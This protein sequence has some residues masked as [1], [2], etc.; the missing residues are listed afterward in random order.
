MKKLITFIGALLVLSLASSFADVGDMKQISKNIKDLDKSLL[1]TVETSS[2][3]NYAVDSKSYTMLPYNI[4]LSRY[5]TD[6]NSINWYNG[7]VEA[8]VRSL[9][10][11]I[12]DGAETDI[13]GATIGGRYNFVNRELQK[14]SL[15]PFVESE[16]GGAFLDSRGNEGFHNDYS[17]VIG[18]GGG[19]AY[20]ISREWFV[21]VGAYYRRF[22]N[23]SDL[24]SLG[25]EIGVGYAF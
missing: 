12:L 11:S 9:N 19:V 13:H 17:T 15:T 4:T 2:G 1:W 20:D 23:G 14:Y 10:G 8:F 21:R 24:N 5:I 3:I 25:S 22:Q 7:Y 16:F 6:V 18:C